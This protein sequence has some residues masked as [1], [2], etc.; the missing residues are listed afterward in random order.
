M[1]RPLKAGLDYFPH[2]CMS[3]QSIDLIQAEFGALG[4]A[5]IYRLYEKIYAEKGYFCEWTKDVAL[6]FS[7][8]NGVGVNVVSEILKSALRRGIFDSGLYS[9]YGILTSKDIQET[10]I[11]A[12]VKR[13]KIFLFKEYLLI[14]CTHFPDYV[15]INSV[16][17][18]INSVNSVINSQSKVKES[19]VNKSKEEKRKS[20]EH[21]IKLPCRNGEYAVNSKQVE[22]LR[23][24]YKN[25]DVMQSVRKMFDFLKANPASQRP[26]DAM[27]NY[28]VMW[29][30]KDEANAL[31]KKKE[32]ANNKSSNVSY[33]ISAFKKYD[34][35]E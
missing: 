27:D 19:K 29:L 26:L 14:N 11:E 13:K 7:Q 1:A 24:I 3:E 8:R 5:V 12:T 35:F 15:C 4:Y 31:S 10:Y 32:E 33:E 28:I 17:G 9:K 23:Q 2:S 21:I 20:P 18:N 34:V 16:N 22:Q 25:I 6:M 30:S